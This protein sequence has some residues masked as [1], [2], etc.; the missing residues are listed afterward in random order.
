MACSRGC[1]ESPAAHYRSVAVANNER[2]LA[3]ETTVTDTEVAVAEVHERWNGQDVTIHPRT[4]A[5]KLVDS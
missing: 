2:R 5:K 3:G 4:V 1:C